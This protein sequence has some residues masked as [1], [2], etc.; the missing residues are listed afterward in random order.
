VDVRQDIKAPITAV[1]Q[2]E[3][4]LVDHI[5]GPKYAEMEVAVPAWEGSCRSI[6]ASLPE[7]S[8]FVTP[9]SNN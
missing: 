1:C 7:I 6:V 9:Q 3:G 5:S 2:L 4:Y 8:N